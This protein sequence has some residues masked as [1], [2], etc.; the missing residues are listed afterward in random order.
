MLFETLKEGILSNITFMSSQLCPGAIALLLKGVD[1]VREAA[2]KIE[3]L[4]FGLGERCS[5]V[6][7]GAGANI[8]L[9]YQYSPR[10]I[11]LGYVFIGKLTLQEWPC[12]G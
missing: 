11:E 2:N 9:E 6:K 8:N 4:S 10:A 3:S 7:V 12:H 5:F 1:L